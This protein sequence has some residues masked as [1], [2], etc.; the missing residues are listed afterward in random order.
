[1][2]NR[3][4][5]NDSKLARSVQRDYRRDADQYRQAGGYESRGSSLMTVVTIG[6]MLRTITMLVVSL[7]VLSSL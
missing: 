7:T 6:I 3:N 4:Q 1:M 5:S 2:F